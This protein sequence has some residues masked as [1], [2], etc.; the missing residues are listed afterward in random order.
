[1]QIGR[2]LLIHSFSIFLVSLL[3]LGYFFRDELKLEQAYHQ[4]LPLDGQ[5]LSILPP[6]RDEALSTEVSSAI[7]TAQK[8]DDETESELKT[9]EKHKLESIP[10]LTKTKID[11][12]NDLLLARKAYWRKDYQTA[13]N[14]YQQMIQED[15]TNPD[16]LGE[17]GNI[18]FALNDYQNAATQYYQAALVLLQSNQHDRA[19]LLISPVTA[20]NR[21]LGNRLRHQ[22]Q[23]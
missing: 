3:I 22:L 11:L 13:I 14:L 8:E 2:W 4:I 7:E 19:R 1:M 21:D 12:N 6:D 16:Y 18:Y 20:M 10:T 23:Q 9:L 15:N 17:L 5:E